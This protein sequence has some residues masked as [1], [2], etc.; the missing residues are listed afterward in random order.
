MALA[1][2]L[3][4]VIGV[5]VE[6]DGAL[7]LRHD[8][9]FASLRTMQVAEG[10]ELI[11]LSQLLAWDL[12]LNIE[13]RERVAAQANSAMFGTIALTERPGDV[14]DVM[15]RYNFPA[16]GLDEQALQTLVLMVLAGGAEARR[17]LT[18]P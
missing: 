5:Q 16:S 7:T 6:D 18:Q 9:T 11:S 10:L 14:A 1:D 12:P 15:L 8:G 3:S 2:V 4:P 17:A 13:L